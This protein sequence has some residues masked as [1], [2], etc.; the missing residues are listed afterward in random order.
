MM[1]IKWF[2][3]EQQIERPNDIQHVDDT[4]QAQLQVSIDQLKAIIEQ[5]NLATDTL[6]TISTSTQ[7]SVKQ[8]AHHSEQTNASTQQVQQEM[9][10]I[11]ASSQEVQAYAEKVQLESI[12]T[13]EGL[14]NANT[15]LQAL[16]SKMEQL[17]AS[18]EVLIEK[19]SQLVEQSNHTVRMIDTIGGISQKTRILALNAA[20]EATRAGEHG[21]GFQVVASEVGKLADL[22]ANAVSDSI[23]NLHTMQQSIHSSSHLVLEES[24]KIDAGTEEIANL[25]DSFN[26]FNVR[27]D[28]IQQSIQQSNVAIGLQTDS[29]QEITILLNDIS[30]MSTDNTNQVL[31]VAKSIEN[32]HAT[33]EQLHTISQ[34]LTSTS[35]SL[36]QLVTKKDVE[37]AIDQQKISA[38]K[39][40]IQQLLRRTTLSNIDENYHQE[41]LRNFLQSEENIE[42]V[43]SNRQ[44]GTFIYSNPRAGLVNAKARQWFKESI[45]GKEFISDVYVSAITKRDCMTISYP[46]RDAGEIVGVI[47]VDITL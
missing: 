4:M 29:I 22:T 46:I 13:G 9:L 10:Q 6:K 21:K 43:W 27:M 33:V 30:D 26:N 25:M 47:G 36:Q 24:Q 32:Q 45:A 23:D 5:S 20:I 1:V 19:M 28:T 8:L 3:K 40:S 38:I 16:M 31:Q 41:I 15:A 17:H 14:Q 39:Q 18:H 35:T 42:A 7:S 34:H 12:Q 2:G 37:I 11:Q 44:D